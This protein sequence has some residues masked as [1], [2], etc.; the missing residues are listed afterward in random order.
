MNDNQKWKYT[1]LNP[2]SLDYSGITKIALGVATDQ[3][4]QVT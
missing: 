1:V 2:S 4:L 3:L